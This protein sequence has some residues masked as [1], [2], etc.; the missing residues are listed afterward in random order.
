MIF[1][2]SYFSS[3]HRLII[4][5]K[6]GNNQ[7]SKRVFTCG[8]YFQGSGRCH[9]DCLSLPQVWLHSSLCVSHVSQSVCF[10]HIDDEHTGRSLTLRLDYFLLL[11]TSIITLH[12]LR[13]TGSEKLVSLEPS[14]SLSVVQAPR[15]QGTDPLSP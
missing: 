8:K 14:S 7:P 4:D 12:E 9:S 11:V 15:H 1:Q 13:L 2:S 3:H 10:I 6:S 5:E